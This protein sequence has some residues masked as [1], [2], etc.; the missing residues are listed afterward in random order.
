MPVLFRCVL[1]D[2][3]QFFRPAGICFVEFRNFNY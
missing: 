3:F 1:I 2:Y